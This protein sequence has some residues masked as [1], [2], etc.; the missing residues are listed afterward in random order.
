VLYEYTHLQELHQHNAESLP[1]YTTQQTDTD[2][3]PTR[4]IGRTH[5]NP[6]VTRGVAKHDTVIST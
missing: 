2:F 4:D 3:N 5:R 1:D 6:K